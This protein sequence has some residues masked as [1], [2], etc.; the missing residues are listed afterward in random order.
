MAIRGAVRYLILSIVLA[1]GACGDSPSEQPALTNHD[2]DPQQAQPPVATHDAPQDATQHGVKRAVPERSETELSSVSNES[3]V[4]YNLERISRG[5]ER[6]TGLIIPHLHKRSLAMA[7]TDLAALPDETLKQLARPEIQARFFGP[8]VH[9][10]DGWFAMINVIAQ[11]TMVRRV[12][13]DVVRA[14]AEPALTP[15]RK[16]EGS[17]LVF[18]RRAT[19]LIVTARDPSL[20]GLLLRFLKNDP[21]DRRIGPIA[22]SALVSY[23]SPWAERALQVAYRSGGP[24]LWKNAATLIARAAG[25]TLD[26]DTMDRLA[27]WSHLV[28][29]SAPPLTRSLPQFKVFSWDNRRAWTDP[30]VLRVAQEGFQERSVPT[31]PLPRS[32]S[33]WQSRRFHETASVAVHGLLLSGKEPAARTRCRLAR[34]DP[35]LPVYLNSVDADLTLKGIDDLLYYRALHCMMGQP[36]TENGE[37]SDPVEQLLMAIGPDREKFAATPKLVIELVQSVP[38]PST[39]ERAKRALF[40]VMETLRPLTTWGPSVQAAYDALE[41]VAPERDERLK[42]MLIGDDATDLSKRSALHAIRRDLRPEYASMLLA[43]HDRQVPEQQPAIRRMLIPLFA[44]RDGI[45]P[46]LF[47]RFLVRHIGWINAAPAKEMSLMA[48]SLLDFGESGIAAFVQG[49]LGPHRMAYITAWPQHKPHPVGLKLARA[50]MNP[51]DRSTPHQEITFALTLAYLTFPAEAAPVL[52]SLGERLGD[53]HEEAVQSVIH[54][55]RRRA[56]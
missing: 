27:W 26:Y 50:L 34:H 10:L 45:E 21:G 35:P 6:T 29:T 24:V 16:R 3:K 48:S 44:K 51:I 31:H 9:V 5:P 25:P 1:L 55:I 4:R 30:M 19:E 42:Q 22:L 38:N 33:G 32:N 7:Q 56:K 28:E 43:F 47:D 8:H 11:L 54:R 46:E 53:K 17:L 15:A 39:D 23:G 36:T 37:R 20:A 40:K 49:L 14:W 13:P 2:A 41:P 12:P 18:R 52:V